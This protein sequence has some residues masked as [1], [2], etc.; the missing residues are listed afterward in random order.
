M[1]SHYR[2]SER[3]MLS[4]CVF[5]C[6]RACIRA[7]VPARACAQLQVWEMACF[8]GFLV[9]KECG[10]RMKQRGHGTIIFTGKRLQ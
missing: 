8:A 6:V 3:R 4:V 7:C 9:G 10:Q 1:L 2:Y 5:V